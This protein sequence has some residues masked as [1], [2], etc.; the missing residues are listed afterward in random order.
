MPLALSCYLPNP[1]MWSDHLKKLRPGHEGPTKHS[2]PQGGWLVSMSLKKMGSK[3]KE[4]KWSLPK[5]SPWCFPSSSNEAQE[6]CK[7][8]GQDSWQER[9]PLHFVSCWDSAHCTRAQSQPLNFHAQCPW[10]QLSPRPDPRQGTRSCDTVMGCGVRLQSLQILNSIRSLP[11]VL[12]TKDN[13]IQFLNLGL[14]CNP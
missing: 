5:W 7:G 12:I 11:E 10:S 13:S 4:R 14:F 6:V 1:N 9:R 3:F 2:K 8:S